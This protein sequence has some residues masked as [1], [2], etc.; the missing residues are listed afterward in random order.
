MCRDAD[1]CALGRKF[2]YLSNQFLGDFSVEQPQQ[3]SAQVSFLLRHN[4]VSAQVSFLLRHNKSVPRYLFSYDTTTFF[5]LCIR[6]YEFIGRYQ[7]SKYTVSTE[8]V[9]RSGCALLCEVFA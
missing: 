6:A 2:A 4:N 3:V 7:M 1:F 5:L 9:L 8:Q